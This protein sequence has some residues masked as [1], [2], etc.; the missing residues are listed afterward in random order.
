MENQKKLVFCKIKVYKILKNRIRSIN[1]KI[2][3]KFIKLKMMNYG[4]S[5]T[6]IIIH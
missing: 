4:P 5:N 6:L 3:Q 2:N 1:F